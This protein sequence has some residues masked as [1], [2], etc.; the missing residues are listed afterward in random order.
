MM[1]KNKLSAEDMIHD[2]QADLHSIISTIEQVRA[3][4]TNDPEYC[5]TVLNLACR[6][7]DQLLE[8]WGQLKCNFKE[9]GE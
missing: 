6:R 5:E 8:K 3:N 1:A 2:F 7:G 9:V 4:L